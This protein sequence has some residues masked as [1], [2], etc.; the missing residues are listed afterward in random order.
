MKY[1]K[2][3][4]IK[5]LSK[6]PGYEIKRDDFSDIYRVYKNGKYYFEYYMKSESDYTKFRVEK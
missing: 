4:F 5:W 6:Q 1:L 2:W 3:N